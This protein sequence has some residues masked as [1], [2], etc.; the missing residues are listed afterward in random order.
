MVTPIDTS[1]IYTLAQ[2][3]YDALEAK[4]EGD[5][6]LSRNGSSLYIDCDDGSIYR[7]TVEKTRYAYRDP[8]TSLE[9][10]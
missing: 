10:T 1:S 2:S 6:T 4:P 5:F 9:S 7:I 3:V 8:R